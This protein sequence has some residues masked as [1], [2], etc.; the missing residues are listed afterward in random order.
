MRP[1]KYLLILAAAAALLAQQGDQAIYQHYAP[2]DITGNWVSIVTEDWSQ[3]M[4]M[5]SKGDYTSIP[6]N[7]AGK[8]VA[9]AWD[10]AHDAPAAGEACRAYAAPALLR[11]PGRL[12]ISWQDNGN[13]L[14]LE[15]DAGQQ[16]RLLQFAG[17]EPQ[18]EAGFQG[19]SAASWDYAGGFD[20][21]RVGAPPA[22]RPNGPNGGGGGGGGNG[23]GNVNAPAT[24]PQGGALKVV[25]THLKP[26]YIRKNGVPY[27]KD[28]VLTEYFNVHKDTDG[29]E[30]LIVTNIVHDP[31]YLAVDY[32]TSSNFR[33]ESDG[34]KWRPKTCTAQ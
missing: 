29:T 33:R 14:K 25:T 18:G 2:I 17:K 3:R 11:V 10:P 30:W 27:S 24:K 28:T 16:T 12:R 34:S 23:R 1:E 5:P 13:T 20:P 9:D 22:V 7:A 6:L 4:I 31:A 21:A 26:G 32:I 19:Y 8:K 15:A